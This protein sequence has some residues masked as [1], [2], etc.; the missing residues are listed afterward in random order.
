MEPNILVSDE[1]SI[2]H[3]VSM[4]SRDMVVLEVG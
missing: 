2:G 1:L 3:L 4:W